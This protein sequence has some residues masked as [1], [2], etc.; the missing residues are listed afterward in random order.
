MNQF[1]QAQ[2]LPEANEN[3]SQI[4]NPN[5]LNLN[6]NL[7]T[8]AER[9]TFIE[10][11]LQGVNFTPTPRELEQMSD[12][13]LWGDRKENAKSIKLKSFRPTKKVESLEFILDTEH[14][15]DVLQ[16][17]PLNYKSPYIHQTPVF[18]RDD[19][20]SKAPDDLKQSLI[21]LYHRIDET[22][23]LI[24]LYKFNHGKRKEFPKTSLLPDEIT[25]LEQRVSSMSIYTYN[26][27]RALLLQLRNEQFIIRDSF[28][29][30]IHPA[31]N[32]TNDTEDELS[33]PT[34][35]KEKLYYI[36]PVMPP[37]DC[38]YLKDILFN[39]LEL[40]TPAD[41]DENDLTILTYCLWQIDP[42]D[43]K[44]CI[45]F[46][47]YQMIRTFITK[48]IELP[49]DSDILFILKFYIEATPMPLAYRTLI[50]AKME[51]KTNVEIVELIQEI[52]DYAYAPNYISTMLTQACKWMAK[53]SLYHRE[54]LENLFFPENFKT[55]IS[56]G[57]TLLRCE[58]NF[59]HRSR[60]GDTYEGRCKTCRPK[61]N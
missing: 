35:N 44:F 28:A 3:I 53:F 39:P 9:T 51:K 21:D 31:V 47:D 60:A 52:Y 32:L 36:K 19:A 58:H 56:C 42:S 37:E 30:Q 6:F 27:L 46:S 2:Y 1:D 18:D 50:Y 40:P 25:R 57:K 59:V 29:P 4:K 61:R 23:F 41:L 16:I 8:K 13:I 20:L 55:C 11:Y 26:R 45:D 22:F 12:Y 10:D 34:N 7:A 33:D 17:H 14:C 48:A 54:V 24:E 43:Y 5:R 49:P 38:Q 15:L